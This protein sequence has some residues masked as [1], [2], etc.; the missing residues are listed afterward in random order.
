MLDIECPS[1]GE[2]DEVKFNG[3]VYGDD[4]LEGVWFYVEIPDEGVSAVT[5]EN[6]EVARE[7][8][9]YFETLDKEKI[10]RK[11]RE[12]WDK[13]ECYDLGLICSECESNISNKNIK[14]NQKDFLD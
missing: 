6:F 11:L 2:V 14:G 7:D 10:T 3:R 12:L 9:D 5:E 1:C 13:N 4:K 8:K